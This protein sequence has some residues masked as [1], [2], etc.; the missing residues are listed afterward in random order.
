MEEQLRCRPISETVSRKMFSG[1]NSGAPARDIGDAL[2]IHN[3]RRADGATPDHLR[4]LTDFCAYNFPTSIG[5]NGSIILSAGTSALLKAQTRRVG[6]DNSNSLL[7]SFLTVS[8]PDSLLP[9]KRSLIK[10]RLPAAMLQSK[11]Q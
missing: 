2:Q 8:T 6:S 5:N 11:R 3:G 4:V 1:Q 7:N 10:I 9:L